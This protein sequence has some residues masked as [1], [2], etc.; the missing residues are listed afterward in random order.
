MSAGSHKSLAADGA[1]LLLIPSYGSRRRRQNQAVVAR[2][3]ETGL[4]V[5]QASVG[6]NLIVDR[7]EMIAYHW[8]ADAI[9]TA[10]IHPRMPP[11][12]RLAREFERDYLAFQADELARRFR[13]RFPARVR[14]GGP[15]P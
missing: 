15:A 9:T 5:V 2:A 7:G 6:V 1:E 11:S 4:P 3:R 10:D 8:G 13:R 12:P 14:D